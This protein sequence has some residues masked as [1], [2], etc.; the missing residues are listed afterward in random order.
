MDGAG[1]YVVVD[2]TAGAGSFASGL[3][4]RFGVTFL[5]T[6]PTRK[7]VSVYGQYREHTVE[8][9]V[10]TAVVGNKVT[11][12]ED[13]AFLREHV[14]DD[15]LT[16]LT[17]SDWVRAREQGRDT[18]SLEPDNHHALGRLR[19]AVD[20]RTIKENLRRS[21]A[22]RGGRPRPPCPARVRHR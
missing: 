6:E 12:E 16:C 3:F 10:P 15:L 5:A 17:H 22:D 13:I 7:S 18:G 21:G 11:G 14:G 9:G 8:F 20:A 1:E 2:M 19:A 4:T